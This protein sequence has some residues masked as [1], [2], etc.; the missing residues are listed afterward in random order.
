[1]GI[2]TGKCREGA[3]HP[4]WAP[5]VSP[6]LGREG[7]WAGAGKGSS[8]PSFHPPPLHTYRDAWGC[9]CIPHVPG[10][11]AWGGGSPGCL[12][13]LGWGTSD[14]ATAASLL[15]SRSTAECH[16]VT[17][18]LPPPA[19]GATFGKVSKGFPA[20]NQT[21]PC[22]SCHPIPHMKAWKGESLC[23]GRRA[24]DTPPPIGMQEVTEPWDGVFRAP[25][26]SS[27]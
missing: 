2:P 7:L 21:P 14:S 4:S 17:Q 11:D 24:E 26:T 8:P 12:P 22:G 13:P 5:G 9:V 19:P 6:A 25:L 15:E 27:L 16:P 10:W 20:R 23:V 3:L 1:M 18:I